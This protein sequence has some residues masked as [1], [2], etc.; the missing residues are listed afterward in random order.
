MSIKAINR[1]THYLRRM[2]QW[3]PPKT[4]KWTIN[5]RYVHSGEI[6][7]TD[8]TITSY[9]PRWYLQAFH[10]LFRNSA[11][12]SCA[13]CGQLIRPNSDEITIVFLEFDTN[14]I[15]RHVYQA[16]FVKSTVT[17]TQVISV[18]LTILSDWR[19]TMQP[20]I[21][22]SITQKFF[23]RRT[24]PSRILTSRPVTVILFLEF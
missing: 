16:F 20:Y 2:P 14:S 13:R 17:W 7:G 6:A 3:P 18:E 22:R 15:I 4:L 9:I 19:Q 11:G 1:K 12:I 5:S 21:S 8:V 23:W 10:Q 24:S